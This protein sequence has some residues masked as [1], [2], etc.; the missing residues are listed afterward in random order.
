MKLVFNC[1]HAILEAAPVSIGEA[2]MYIVIRKFNQMHS[3]RE[4]ARRAE[5]GLGEILKKSPGFRGYYVFDA[6]KGVAGS[7]TLFDTQ[8]G[9]C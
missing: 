9:G 6:G 3:V 7:V 1:F 8:P 2:G 4:A 5:T